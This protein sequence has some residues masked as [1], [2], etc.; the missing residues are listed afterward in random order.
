MHSR[1]SLLAAA[2][3]TA[4]ATAGCLDFLL[5]EDLSFEATATSVAPA[6]LEATGYE[7][8]RVREETV[9]RTFEAGDESRTVEV[10]NVRAE[11]EKSIDL[12]GLGG[13][14]SAPAATFSAVTSPKVQVLDQAFNPLRV[15]DPADVVSMAQ[16]RY[17]GLGNLSRTGELRATLLGTETT[18]TQ[19]EGTA[20]LV[21]TDIDLLIDL[22]VADAVASGDDYALVVAGHPQVL[23]TQER[24]HVLALTTGVEHDG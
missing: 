24:E 4:A 11:Y 8:R 23:S 20:H 2:T 18:L 5:G 15:L 10:T 17:E 7:R 13:E 1:R 21:D 6:T 22:Y 16:G 9:E 12:G 19:F 14:G 3:A